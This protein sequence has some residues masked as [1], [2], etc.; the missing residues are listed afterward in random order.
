MLITEETFK[1]LLHS[2]KKFILEIGEKEIGEKKVSFQ[3]TD[4]PS[5]KYGIRCFL[6][7]DG[8]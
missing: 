2:F 4:T 1:T 5:G 8:N 7:E 6:D 3:F